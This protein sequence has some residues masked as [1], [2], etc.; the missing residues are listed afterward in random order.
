MVSTELDQRRDQVRKEIYDKVIEVHGLNYQYRK[1]F[2]STLFSKKKP[3]WSLE[4]P[5]LSIK[6][7]FVALMGQSG[8]GKSTLLNLLSGL[9][10][11]KQ[12]QKEKIFFYD[13]Q[14]NQ[15]P[16]SLS[17]FEQFR[18]ENFGY[19][20]QRC[21]ESKPLTVIQNV[22][23]PLLIKKYSK[24]DVEEYSKC[25]LDSLELK[26][27]AKKNAEEL[28]GGQLSR[29]GAL[30]GIA[31]APTVLFVDEPASSLDPRNGERIMMALKHWQGQKSDR[32]VI[33]ATH[34]Q[35]HVLDYADQ[36]IILGKEDGENETLKQKKPVQVVYDRVIRKAGI[37]DNNKY[38]DE[39]RRDIREKLG[40]D[41][42]T[43]KKFPVSSPEKK[44]S[45]PGQ[46]LAFLT[47][48]AYKNVTSKSDGSR[49]ISLITFLAFFT[50][51]MIA[52]TGNQ[53]TS[54]LGVI[55]GIKNSSAYLT[56]FEVSVREPSF[57]SQEVETGINEVEVD[58]IM[59]H[60][61]TSINRQVL[62]I[63]KRASQNTTSKYWK[64]AL[65]VP[66]EDSLQSVPLSLSQVLC[67]TEKYSHS[68]GL[69]SL[70][71]SI[72]CEDG[73][74][75][76]V[77]KMLKSNPV[78]LPTLFQTYRR[79]LNDL[80]LAN[81]QNQ[82]INI[83][84]LKKLETDTLLLVKLAEYYAPLPE[85]SLQLARSAQEG[86]SGNLVSVFPMNDSA[87]VFVNSPGFKVVITDQNQLRRSL[88]DKLSKDKIAAVIQKLEGLSN[89]ATA[90][91]SRASI[92]RIELGI[93]AI[94]ESMWASKA[95]T[96]IEGLEN[97]FFPSKS[98][99]LEEIEGTFSDEKIPFPETLKELIKTSLGFQSESLF[100]SEMEPLFAPAQFQQLKKKLTE[101]ETQSD[102]FKEKLVS[103]KPFQGLEIRKVGGRVNSDFNM[104]W[105][106]YNDPWFRTTELNFLAY[107]KERTKMNRDGKVQ[108][109]QSKKDDGILIT[110]ELL[111]DELGYSLNAKEI[112]VSYGL[113]QTCIPVLAVVER[114][115][116]IEDYQVVTNFNF[117]RKIRDRGHHCEN[118]RKYGKVRLLY[119]PKT[120]FDKL[121]FHESN[122]NEKKKFYADPVD[123]KETIFDIYPK[124]Q[125]KL[126]VMTQT[127]WKQWIQTNLIAD[128]SLFDLQFKE[129]WVL[130]EESPSAP[131]IDRGMIYA[132]SRKAVLPLG[133]Y[134]SVA[135]KKDPDLEKRW[136]ITPLEY[137]QKIRFAKQSETMRKAI[138]K[139]GMVLIGSIFLLF[140][141]TN[142]MINIRN[143]L[144]EIAIFR[145]M[146]GKVL[147]SIYIFSTQALILV[148]ASMGTALAFLYWLTPM[149]RRE[150][151]E[152]VISLI[153]KNPDEQRIAIEVIASSGSWQDL[154]N[155]LGNSALIIGGSLG[156]VLVV[157]I[158]MILN[159]RWNPKY[160]ISQI[161]KER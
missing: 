124:A 27:E 78:K 17:N 133:Y 141:V 122:L 18:T 102:L 47:Q 20:F 31:Q 113:E 51:F 15:T 118:R 60:Y 96:Q 21:Y 7:G 44:I 158:L 42:G 63:E 75:L 144:P 10:K 145:A 117:G 157:V 148:G 58:H 71:K 53:L 146:G 142:M 79:Y 131:H 153:W 114:I 160:T 25:L 129:D 81:R 104:L 120:E 139:T 82:R 8:M 19:I 55:D 159:I 65:P 100:F 24:Q 116:G 137:E 14:G 26:D 11:L 23:L 97:V 83:R 91:L 99:L 95:M 30:R 119:K 123:D 80:L 62:Q 109:F 70:G 112:R 74:F 111:V 87:P 86:R 76:G 143:K 72:G 66:G 121:W 4:I 29:I 3:E 41:E 38:L 138:E 161:L 94:L 43:A 135:F 37:P 152:K 61:Q 45:H 28:S 84:E 46:Y 98:R 50:L 154:G 34:T 149:I 127:Q 22:S 147:S 54:W 6:P 92:H 108:I 12:E 89:P 69:F 52:F 1:P 2:W 88:S 136:N 36:V 33:M 93:D 57:L 73:R 132:H 115:P 32:T 156:S 107:N 110:R 140:F 68:P 48:V 64:H 128:D 103:V 155:L 151:S 56:S 40:V 126:N 150:F 101:L 105:L 90:R 35:E 39:A 16:Y 130:V 49:T 85:V 134:L 5:H 13:E 9:E 125:N 77:D 106:R 67:G 59:E